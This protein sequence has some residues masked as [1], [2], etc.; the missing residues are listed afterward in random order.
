[1]SPSTDPHPRRFGIRDL[2]NDTSAVL[3]EAERSGAVDITRNGR[4]VARL[5]PH[6]EQAETASPTRQLLD[7]IAGAD[8]RATGWAAEYERE[9]RADLAA[10]Q[11]SEWG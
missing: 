4:V 8:G 11:D 1:M 2:R 7:R 6:R 5:V 9:K 3:A 10:E